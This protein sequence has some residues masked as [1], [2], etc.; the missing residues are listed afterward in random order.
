MDYRYD[1]K[2]F[3][4]V[5]DKFLEDNGLE[6]NIFKEDIENYINQFYLNNKPQSYS[7]KIADGEFIKFHKIDVRTKAISKQR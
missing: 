3:L 7:V 2:Y 1:N 6:K 5:G 4:I